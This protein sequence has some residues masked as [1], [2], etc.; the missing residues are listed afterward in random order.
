MAAFMS[1]TVCPRKCSEGQES[2]LCVKYSNRPKPAVDWWV[3]MLYEASPFRTF[4]TT[5]NSCIFR[6][7]TVLDKVSFRCDCSDGEFWRI[8]SVLIDLFITTSASLGI[9]L[10]G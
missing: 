10:Q 7:H 3:L 2:A 9:F 6:I 1:R 4:A 8:S 5:A